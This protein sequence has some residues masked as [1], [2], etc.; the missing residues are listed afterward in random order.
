MVYVKMVNSLFLNQMFND[1]P[2]ERKRTFLE[3]KIH[4]YLMHRNKLNN[5]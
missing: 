1:D 5:S 4:W 3:Y 2:L